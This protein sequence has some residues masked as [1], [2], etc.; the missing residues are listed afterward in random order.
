MKTLPFS[1]LFAL[2]A[3]TTPANAAILRVPGLYPSIQSAI[4]AAHPLDVIEVS[5]G[6][7]YEDLVIANKSNLT[8]RAAAG[9]TVIVDAGGSGHALLIGGLG[10]TTTGIMVKKLSLRS[11]V[12]G[13]GVWIGFASDIRIEKCDISGVAYDGVYSLSSTS[14]K[15][16][17]CTITSPGRNGITAREGELSANQNTITTPGHDGIALA[18]RSHSAVSNRILSPGASGIRLGDGNLLTDFSLVQDN[19]ISLAQVDG[20]VCENNVRSGSI[21]DNQIGKCQDDGIDLVSG[22][23]WMTVRGNS[24]NR[25]SDSGIQVQSSQNTFQ[26][27]RIKKPGV[28]GFWLSSGATNGLYEKNRVN[29]SIMDGFDVWGTNNLFTKNKATGSLQFDLREHMAPGANTYLGNNFGTI[30]P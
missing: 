28:D 30:A 19:Q 25:C 4:S 20:I 6:T 1:A 29:K 11:S 5:G 27:N 26:Q 21:L 16:K 12:A 9:A 18:G 10:T 8:L 22:S 24:I 3:A 15:V 23:G 2:L 14:V 17:K 13:S 7:Y